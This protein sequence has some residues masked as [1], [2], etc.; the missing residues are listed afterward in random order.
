MCATAYLLVRLL[1]WRA[2]RKTGFA[3]SARKLMMELARIRRCRLIERSGRAGRPRVR[4][5]SHC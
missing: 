1:L 3:G 2:R 4:P 5:Y